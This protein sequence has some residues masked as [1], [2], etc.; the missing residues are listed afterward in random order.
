MY[1]TKLQEL[2]HKKSWN[3]PEYSTRREG[4]DHNPRHTATVTVNGTDFHSPEPCRAAKE[5]QNN[6]AKVAFE[7]FWV[8]PTPSLPY[9]PSFPPPP[10]PSN[11]PSFPPPPNPSNAPSFPPPP[12]PSNAPSFPNLS[13]PQPSFPQ[14]HFVPSNFPQ[15]SFSQPS[16]PQPSAPAPSDSLGPVSDVDNV[17]LA[18]NVLQPKLKEASETSQISNPVSAVEDNTKARDQRNDLDMQRL[19]KNQLQNYVQKRNL[20]LPVYTFERE[21]PSH[22]SRFKCKVTVNGETYESSEF[23]STLKDAEHAAAK[24]ALMSLPTEI[25]QEDDTALYKNLLQELVQKKGLHLPV[26]STQKSGEAHR[27]IF[28]S[29]V[30]LEGEVFTGQEAKTKKQAEMNAAKVA[31]TKLQDLK[32]KSGQSSLVSV[33]THQGQAPKILSPSAESN[34]TTGLQ[35]NANLKSVSP[36]LVTQNLSKIDE[37]GDEVSIDEITIPSSE[38]VRGERGLSC[39]T[40]GLVEGDSLTNDSCSPSLSNCTNVGAESSSSP[41]HKKRVTVL[42]RKTNV[43]IPKGGTLLPISDEQWVAYSYSN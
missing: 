27:P 2:C 14:L 25:T 37:V 23:F 41:S 3:L 42:S 16:L 5:A 34:V 7:H 18:R 10:D 43:S 35:Y 9:S 4:P 31:Y 26:Y 11:A 1:K 32:G 39:I 6:A 38:P 20:S 22:N 8:L 21:G 30:E 19:Y 36:G 15:P 17:F 29:S 12:N 28:I 33:F 40:D 13:F 24:V